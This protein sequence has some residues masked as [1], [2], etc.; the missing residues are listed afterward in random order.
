[1]LRLKTNKQTIYRLQVKC[2]KAE[3]NALQHKYEIYA[4]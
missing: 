1:M 3:K 4:F 2:Q